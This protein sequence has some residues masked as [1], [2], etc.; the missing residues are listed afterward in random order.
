MI[1]SE[2]E[3]NMSFADLL[4]NK[5]FI[6]SAELTPPRHYI[7]SDFMRKAEIVDEYVDVIQLND[8]LLSK[9]RINNIIPG[10]QCK[11]ANMEVIL[12][13]A[14]IHK[15]RIAI[16]G[17]LLAMAA[18]DLQNLIVLGGYPCSIGSDPN[19]HDVLDL[20]AIQAIQKIKNLT[21][22]G[23]LFNGEVLS[24]PPEFIVGTID[25]PCEK[26]NV[27]KG[28]DRLEKKIEAGADFVQIQAIF[29]LGRLECWM[30]E[31]VKRNLHKQVRFLGAVFP[32]DSAERLHALREIPGLD[33]PEKLVRYMEKNNSSIASSKI[34]L[35]LVEGMKNI[36]AISGIH[37]RS[38]GA[39]EWVP[40]IVEASGL[41]G[42]LVY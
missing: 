32:F 38:I 12:Q 11:L 10:Q 5:E 15:N 17:D 18:S 8:H 23:E 33:V 24:P 37:I 26:S 41:G 9:A 13:F 2:E 22:N 34:T 4:K 31:V 6:V 42:E 25:F 29:E 14:L 28:V 27:I 36:D 20:N 30:A 19:A 3:E 35:D 1:K 7:L 21:E 16:Q 39:E 40:K